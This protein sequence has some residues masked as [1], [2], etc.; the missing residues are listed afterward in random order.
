MFATLYFKNVFLIQYIDFLKNY[1]KIF[2][3]LN[4]FKSIYMIQ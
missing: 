2:F 4:I 3:R 1:E